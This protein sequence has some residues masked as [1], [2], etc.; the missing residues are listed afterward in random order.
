[1]SDRW[2]QRHKNTSDKYQWLWLMVHILLSYPLQ[3]CILQFY[4]KVIFLDCRKYE[5]VQWQT[6]IPWFCH[7]YS[8]HCGDN[9]FEILVTNISDVNIE[10]L[11][12]IA[13]TGRISLRHASQG[14]FFNVS[15]TFTKTTSSGLD[16]LK[17]WRRKAPF[18]YFTITIICLQ[19]K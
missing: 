18:N 2:L 11:Y 15:A 10:H 4:L 14:I 7:W 12:D 8:C 17:R 13:S 1:M 6:I 19:T 5:I 9:Y 3:N 16:A